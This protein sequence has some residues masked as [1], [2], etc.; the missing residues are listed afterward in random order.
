MLGR[1][2]SSMQWGCLVLLTAGVALVQLNNIE[3]DA[4]ARAASEGI[5]FEAGD[6]SVGIPDTPEGVGE[7]ATRAAIEARQEAMAGIAS[8]GGEAADD[9]GATDGSAT[10]GMSR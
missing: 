10:S 5:D 1:V 9:G 7:D 2:L 6:A 8:I 3:A 4:A